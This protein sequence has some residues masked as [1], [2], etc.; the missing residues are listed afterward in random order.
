M[1]NILKEINLE[2]KKIAQ[3][4]EIDTQRLTELINIRDRLKGYATTNI[5]QVQGFNAQPVPT[6]PVLGNMRQHQG[7]SVYDSIVDI[8]NVYLK[9][10]TKQL[11]DKNNIN[12]H[13]LMFYYKFITELGYRVDDEKTFKIKEDIEQLIMKELENIINREKNIEKDKI[14]ETTLEVKNKLEVQP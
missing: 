6:Y 1:E 13:D 10:Q 7:N 12:I 14:I 3:S 5:A 4:E 8:A 2:I 9:N 11:N